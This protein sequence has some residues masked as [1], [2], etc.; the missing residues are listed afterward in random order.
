MTL[1][2]KRLWAAVLAAAAFVVTAAASAEAATTC[3]IRYRIAGWSIF[4]KTSSG[5]GTIRCDNGQRAEV[6]LE[7]KGGGVTVG[8]TE[9]QGKGTFSA[10]DDIRQL[11]GAYGQAEA[12]AGVVR[13]GEV[14]VVTKGPVSLALAG[15]GRGVDLGISFGKLEIEP[16]KDSRR[17]A[18]DWREDDEAI[19]EEQVQEDRVQEK[20]AAV[21][22][23][24][25]DGY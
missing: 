10:V 12:H 21:A 19:L 3:T 16:R 9:I 5:T 8:R 20:D 6:S 13:S 7:A 4:Y 25:Q 11:Y 1:G 15:K 14:H 22:P 24:R 18:Q 17:A 2:T 23:P